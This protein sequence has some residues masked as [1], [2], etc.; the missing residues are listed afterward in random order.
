MKKERIDPEI[1][2]NINTLPPEMGEVLLNWY[3]YNKRNLPWRED[4]SPYHVWVS[5]IMLQQTRVEAVAAYYYRFMD[6]LPDLADLARV[7][8]DELMKLWEGLGYYSRARNLKKA[9]GLVMTEYQGQLPSTRTEL[10]K[11]PGIGE[12]TAGAIA[13]IAFGRKEPAIDGNMMRIF[14]RLLCHPGEISKT[15]VKRDVREAICRI[16]PEERPGD[17]NQALMD[18]GA[19]ICLPNGRPLCENCPWSALCLAHKLEKESDYPVK[20]AK[21]ARRIEH[22]T[23]LLIECG[24]KRILHRRAGR[25]LLAGLYEY[26][27]LSGT[28]SPEKLEEQLDRWGFRDYEL[29]YYK[30]GKHIFS[31]V[32][33]RMQAYRI[34]IGEFPPYL[35]EK[36]NWLAVEREEVLHQYAI[37]S[38]FEMFRE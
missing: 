6:R 35:L 17:F 22:L 32:E 16:M 34:R 26:P 2:K 37:P 1:T 19:T 18:L 30:K 36:M 33:W 7:P 15:A 3:D 24:E 11:L 4:P 20:K 38:A 13:S 5:E 12:Y 27:N 8:E 9:A 14:S 10:E 29:E 21:K 28:F 25:G 23:V 31:H